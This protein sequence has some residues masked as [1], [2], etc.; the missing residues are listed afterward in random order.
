M[1]RAGDDLPAGPSGPGF[2]PAPLS[3]HDLAQRV[4]PGMRMLPPADRAELVARQAERAQRQ[5]WDSP[6]RRRRMASFAVGGALCFPL[7]DLLLMPGGARQLL[8]G[9]VLGAGI[10]FVLGV[11]RFSRLG[12]GLCTAAYVP[13]L[14]VL[15][16]RPEA[17]YRFAGVLLAWIYFLVGFAA[18]TSDELT[19][20]ED[21]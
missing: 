14:L 5:R 11:R 4:T 13:L 1:A 16:G 3:P 12:A 6:R 17:A 10:G 19:H 18:G 9:A 2:D 20:D 8:L 7:L 15:Q 21:A